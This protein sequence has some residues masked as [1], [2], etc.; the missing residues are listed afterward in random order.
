M[1]QRN[2]KIKLILSVLFFSFFS[3][4]LFNNYVFAADDVKTA[5]Q[6]SPVDD[7]VLL[8]PGAS[9]NNNL[10]I[11]NN[12]NEAI[13]FEVE[14]LPFQVTK[15]DYTPVFNVKNSYTQITNWMNVS[16]EKYTLNPGES[17]IAYY[18]INVPK[19]APGGGQYAAISILTKNATGENQSVSVNARINYIIYA[20]VSGVT[21]ETGEII[22][23]KVSGFL[24]AP[25]IKASVKL[26]NTGN[27]DQDAKIIVDIENAITGAKLY[28]NAENPKETSLLPETEKT[29][30][31]SFDNVL[32]LGIMSV[33]MTV[34]YLGNAEKI[35]R[36]VIILPI[37]F[38]LI[39]FA[40]IILIVYRIMAKKHSNNRKRANSRGHDT[41]SKNFNI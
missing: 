10:T 41:P 17:T 30:D 37:W 15:E 38:L 20:R 27:V 11:T 14:I 6:I 39:I 23:K 33:T 13:T 1:I 35:V 28:S 19:D 7:K 3:L 12:S 24:L 34:E 25:P 9:Y 4:F 32:K 2:K 22:E 26:S 18:S 21:R 29:I 40:I 31:M 5:I 36:T 8:D 16:A